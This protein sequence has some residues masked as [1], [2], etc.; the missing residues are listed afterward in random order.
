M[1][2]TEIPQ[3]SP[4]TDFLS[5]MLITFVCVFIIS[6]L[7]GIVGTAIFGDIDFLTSIS[8]DSP[9]KKYYFY[10]FLGLSSAGTFLLP[11]YIYQC[12][13]E[14]VAI[15][16]KENISDWKPYLLGILFLFAFS[17]FMSLI[18][19]W[20]M[21]MKLPEAWQRIEQWMRETEDEA[22]LLM[23]GLLMTT[24]WDRLVLNIIVLAILPGIGEELFFRGALQQIGTRIFKN[25]YVAIWIVAVIFSTIH[26]QFYG[27]FPRFL[28]GVFFGYMV[29]W[30]RNIWTAIVA[31][32]VNN[33]MVV[34]LGFYYATQGKSYTEL[35]E[36]DSYSII[37]YLG[38]LIFSIII[39]FIFYQYT[40]RLHIYGKRVD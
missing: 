8:S 12:R 15:L 6:L 34:I 7:F 23:G 9:L 4:W 19:D 21:Q 40:T 32:F 20:N 3:K 31:H 36:S 24:E 28:L 11:A 25:E 18:S 1:H 27:F 13:N 38:S 2:K 29:I 37:V 16:P 26:V 35:M 33:S 14:H 30:T 17:P 10:I 5:L 22:A 39:A